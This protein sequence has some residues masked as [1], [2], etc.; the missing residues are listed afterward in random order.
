MITFAR[1]DGTSHPLQSRFLQPKTI[2]NMKEIIKIAPAG[3]AK[4]N[5]AEYTNFATR[6]H[7]L[8]NAAGFAELGLEDTA[9]L[10]AYNDLLQQMNDL[11]AQS[12]TSNRTAEM[13]EADRERD[14]LLTYL[15]ALIRNAKNSPIADERKAGATLYN[16]TKPY[17]GIQRLPN[18]QETVQVKGLILDL[19]KAEYAEAYQ[20]LNLATVIEHLDDANARYAT[21]TEERAS[22]RL[23]SQMDNSK[24]V[25]VQMDALYDYITTMG[26]VQSVAKPTEK[27]AQFVASLNALI[28]EV[29]TLYNQRTAQTKKAK[30]AE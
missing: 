9:D 13:A 25:R 7:A 14:D 28:A 2:F 20:A 21:L 15:F 10:E 12:R 22:S 24:T 1:R 23:A 30:E 11:V 4:L 27:T 6:F 16:L 5:N 8:A 19:N 29:N 26:F 3:L 18:Q 17:V